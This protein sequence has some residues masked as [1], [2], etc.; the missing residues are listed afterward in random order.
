M[1]AHIAAR[2]AVSP[3]PVFNGEKGENC[4]CPANPINAL[5]ARS[6]LAMLACISSYKGFL[7]VRGEL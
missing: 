6:Q 2:T 4:E 1:A 5:Y 7:T 3:I